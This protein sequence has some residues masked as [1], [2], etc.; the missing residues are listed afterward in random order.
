MDR[1]EDSDSRT[2]DRVLHG[3]VDLFGHLY[4]RYYA[5]M[6]AIAYSVL[7]DHHFAE[8]AAQ[9]GFLRALRSLQNLRRKDRFA[10]WLAQI[11]RNVAKNMA[12]AVTKSRDIDTED[13]AQAGSLSGSNHNDVQQAVRQALEA[14]PGD[15]RELI[16]LRYYDNSSYEHI[17]SV[18]GISTAAI[19]SRRLPQKYTKLRIGAGF[20]RKQ[21]TYVEE[22]AQ[23]RLVGDF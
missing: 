4:D 11:C 23:N 16:V 8:D 9:E 5:S 2:V 21:W 20:R 6:V 19:N 22:S 15:A 1:N 14:I 17:S 12:K 3:D 7:G 13:V 18:L 10:P